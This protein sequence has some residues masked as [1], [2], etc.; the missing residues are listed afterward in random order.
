MV[1]EDKSIT[2]VKRHFERDSMN[3][4]RWK[5]VADWKEKS[6]YRFYIPKKAITDIMGYENDSTAMEFSTFD[7]E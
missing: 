5:L 4:C 2:P 3:M 6:N 7:P 1:A